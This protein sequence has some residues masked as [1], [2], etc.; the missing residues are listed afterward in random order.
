[1]IDFS[2]SPKDI[3]L[4]DHVR[5]FVRGQ[6]ISFEKDARLM[7]HGPTD[8]LCLKLN[9]LARQAG[10]HAPQVAPAYGG[11]GLSHMQR[12]LVFE[13]AGYFILDPIA[14]HLV[15]PDEGHMY[16]LKQVASQAQ[17]ET[18]PRRIAFVDE[19][20]K[21]AS[22]KVLRRVLGNEEFLAASVQ[23]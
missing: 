22:G 12:A 21:N 15:A 2:I 14:V 20:S 1:M 10:L 3:A 11:L 7:A 6:I 16:L 23:K 4:R 19:L 13:A 9:S 17:K 5:V 8:D 18:Y